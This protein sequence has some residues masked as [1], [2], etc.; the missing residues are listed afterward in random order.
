MTFDYLKQASMSVYYRTLDSLK[1]KRIGY[2]NL[3]NQFS[4]EIRYGCVKR[5][6]A[7]IAHNSYAN[8]LPS[9]EIIFKWLDMFGSGKRWYIDYKPSKELYAYLSYKNNTFTFGNEL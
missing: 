2:H 7:A 5:L 3:V 9:I 4:R 1:L 8:Y 6:Q